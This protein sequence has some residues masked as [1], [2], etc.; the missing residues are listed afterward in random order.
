MGKYLFFDIDGTL[1]SD[2][3]HQVPQSALEA[4]K[5]AKE[6]GHHCFFCTGRSYFMTKEISFTGIEDAII[7]NGAAVIRDGEP[8]LQKIIS[9]DVVK[10]T[11]ELIEKLGGGYQIID[12][13]YG[14]QNPFTHALF[15]EK[16][17]KEFDEPAEEIFKRKSMKTIDERENNPILKIDATFDTVEAAQRF[18]D[19]LDPSLTFIPAGGYTSTFG[20]K[21]GEIMLKGVSKGASI[22]NFMESIG[23]PMENAYA[24]GDS[25]NDIEMMKAAG[26]AIAMGNGADAVKAAADYITDTVD[27]DGLF[28][29]MAHYKL[30]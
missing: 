28:K 25:T 20:A 9:N 15:K 6:K 17:E 8:K 1:I 16:F 11:L 30:I 29:A 19:A 26:T 21:A 4:I 24:F 18:I 23:E 14:Y 13:K 27:A 22:Q 3:T 12:W 10:K 5:K 2:V 7:A